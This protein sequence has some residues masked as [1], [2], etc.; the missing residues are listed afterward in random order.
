GEGDP[1]GLAVQR[2]ATFM[3]R[4]IFLVSTPTVKG[5]SRI[6][7]A[8]EESDKRIF[9]VPCDHCGAYSQLFWK[10]IRWPEGN[11]Q[12]AAWHCPVCGGVHPEHRKPALLAQ[13]RWTPTAF[14]DGKTAGFH[15]SSLYS[16]WLTWGE[17]AAE[18]QAAKEDPVRLKVWVNTKLAETW[19]ERDGER[20]DETALMTRRESYGPA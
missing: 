17:I 14:G 7:S 15:L 4:K 2:T 19:E 12:E 9:V 1:V 8:Y 10:D 3:N 20:M 5:F 11:L 13:G 6:E 18:H 16:P